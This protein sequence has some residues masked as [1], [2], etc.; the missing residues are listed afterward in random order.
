MLFTR[1]VLLS[2]LLLSS[3]ILSAEGYKLPDKEWR[4]ISLPSQP[5]EKKSTVKDL[6]ED[7]IR[8][9]YGTDWIMFEFDT[10]ANSY[11]EPLKPDDPVEHGRGYWIT[12]IT[13]HPVTLTMP[14]NSNEAPDIYPLQPAS[15][16]GSGSVQWTLTGNPFSSSLKLGDL[17]LKT[18]SDTCGSIPCDLGKA[19]TE[20]LLHNQVWIYR[21]NGYVPKDTQSTLNAWDGFW[22]ASLKKSEGRAL[23][24]R[25]IRAR[26]FK[27]R[28]TPLFS[29][30]SAWQKR[31]DTA[32]VFVASGTEG[33]GDYYGSSHNQ[34]ETTYRILKGDIYYK[35][36][37]DGI[38]E[39][40]V[41]NPTAIMWIGVDQWTIPIFR[42][43]NTKPKIKIG[44][45]E[46]DGDNPEPSQT[47]AAPEGKIRPSGPGGVDSD[48]AL[49]LFNPDSKP[50]TSW[51][52]WQ[53]RVEWDGSEN[54][55]EV[56]GKL[57]NEKGRGGVISDQLF[58]AGFAT[59]FNANE[60]GT[61]YD[62][63]STKPKD[64]ASASGYSHLAGLLLPEDFESGE[65]KHA[66]KFAIPGVRNRS[67]SLD[68]SFD[69]SKQEKKDYKYPA[70][71]TE[72]KWGAFNPNKDAMIM[73]TRIRLKGKGSLVDTKGKEVEEDQLYP[74][75]RM[76][77][78]A[79]RNYG[80]YLSDNAGGFQ[81][82]AEDIHTG[83]LDDNKLAALIGEQKKKTQ[84]PWEALITKVRDE[85]ANI[86]LAYGSADRGAEPSGAKMEHA[87][88]EV[89][90]FAT[91]P[92]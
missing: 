77:L 74:A 33:E 22:M 9:V 66:L 4:I 37:G 32:K 2:L 75:T 49:V 45:C 15:V 88:F 79:L 25:K 60:D 21:K 70:S 54:E 24:L 81:F 72:D 57:C 85:L 6:F 5:P 3:S 90:D 83:N 11:G 82:W 27:L 78:A 62:S 19:E 13:G 51:E 43:S 36:A 46:Y 26:D 14:E 20:K 80:A 63:N 64:S 42:A 73:G 71:S 52:F 61:S 17:S 76:V 59:S 58:G 65:I 47:V 50:P 69:G 39:T 91:P 40:K 86:P 87:N 84:T 23:S 7:D 41:T 92:Q 12:Q 67:Q 31:A 35:A 16:T 38:V 1:N 89:V 56:E 48:G 10:Q 53:A 34:I 18:D 29:K 44:I 55:N 8:G 30:Q 68:G 28:P